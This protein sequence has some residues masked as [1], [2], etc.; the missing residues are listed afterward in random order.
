M[1]TSGRLLVLFVVLAIVSM[2]ACERTTTQDAASKLDEAGTI[3]ERAR[4]QY[5]RRVALSLAEEASI[6][7]TEAIES[8]ELQPKQLIDA[9]QLRASTRLAARD[10]GG[11]I[12]DLDHVLS[13]QPRNVRALWRRAEAHELIDN[14]EAAIADLS[15][16]LSFVDDKTGL[17][18]QRGRILFEQGEFNSAIDDLTKEIEND[19]GG[20][21]VVELRGDAYAELTKYDESLSDYRRA[22]EME[23][24]LRGELFETTPADS[25]NP[26]EI[27]LRIKAATVLERASRIEEAKTEYRKVLAAEPNNTVAMD[28]L[29]KISDGDE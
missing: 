29:A 2:S 27:D 7:L 13:L 25:F 8:G 22:I 26:A 23:Q 18:G 3:L 9:L 1:L 19:P 11:A 12:L 16:L 6:L 4:M 24:R 21:A 15:D 5:D 10:Y 20:I 17:Y 28:R 14:N